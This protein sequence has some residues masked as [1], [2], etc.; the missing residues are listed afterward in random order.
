MGELLE[1]FSSLDQT[2]K[3]KQ[4]AESQGESERDKSDSGREGSY[5]PLLPPDKEAASTET[6]RQRYVSL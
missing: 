5:S 4:R 3:E 1:V 6:V 2:A